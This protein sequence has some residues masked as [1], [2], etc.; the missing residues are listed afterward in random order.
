MQTLVWL[1]GAALL[2]PVWPPRDVR[3]DAGD[4]VA[5]S[6]KTPDPSSPIGTVGSGTST[7]IYSPAAGVFPYYC[8]NHGVTA[9]MVGAVSVDP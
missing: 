5:G 6:V 7:P 8:N 4:P 9:N 1:I 2:A 3:A